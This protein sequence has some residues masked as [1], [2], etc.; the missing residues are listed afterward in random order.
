M[1]VRFRYYSCIP[2]TL[3]R[4]RMD[5]CGTRLWVQIPPPE[6]SCVLRLRKM[7]LA[8]ITHACACAQTAVVWLWDVVNKLRV[9][10]QGLPSRVSVH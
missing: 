5:R 10:L 3:L 1:S 8:C 4:N 9:R 2:C 7:S 6:R